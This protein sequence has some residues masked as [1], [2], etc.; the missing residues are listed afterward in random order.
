M[1]DVFCNTSPLIYLHRLG[2]LD[3][4]RQLHGKVVIPTAVRDEIAT[5]VLLKKDVPV[6]SGL[7]WLEERPAPLPVALDFP[8]SLG[9][10][11]REAILL[12]RATAG[13][14]V[15]LDDKAARN[16]AAR[17]KLKLAG[18]LA[19]LVIAHRRSLIGELEPILD[20]LVTRGFRMSQTLR[21][22]T[23]RQGEMPTT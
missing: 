21:D 20:M 6:L 13:S 17:L 3:L 2:L 11:E 16:F 14:V 15:L 7:T 22:I 18:T 8:R 1:S 5:G 9:P 12:A 19:T 23:I 10:G 4:L